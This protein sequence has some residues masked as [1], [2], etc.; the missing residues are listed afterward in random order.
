VVS[1]LIGTLIVV[2]LATFVTRRSGR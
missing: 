2:L 1:A